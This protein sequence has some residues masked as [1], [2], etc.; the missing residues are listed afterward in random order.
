MGTLVVFINTFLMV[1]YY[2][3]LKL[4]LIVY[5]VSNYVKCNENIVNNGSYIMNAK[6]ESKD[7]L[8]KS[9]MIK[10]D[11]NQIREEIYKYDDHKDVKEHDIKSFKNKSSLYKL[12]LTEQNIDMLLFQTFNILLHGLVNKSSVY[13]GATNYNNFNNNKFNNTTDID[14][15]NNYIALSSADNPFSIIVNYSSV[16]EKINNSHYF[17]YRQLDAFWAFTSLG[18]ILVFLTLGILCSNLLKFKASSFT[19]SV[20]YN[21]AY[22]NNSV[23]LQK[24]HYY[25][26]SISEFDRLLDVSIEEEDNDD[27]EI[28]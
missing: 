7:E 20:N 14:I 26:D 18:S 23:Y 28:E 8:T 16:S 22:E 25:T 24:T 4:C 5:E 9:K 21:H 3:V 12:N 27:Y 6:Q 2:Y 17:Q 10:S 15:N 1:T 19:A 11:Q 13:I